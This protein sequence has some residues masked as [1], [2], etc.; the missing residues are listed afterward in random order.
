MPIKRKA[1]ACLRVAKAAGGRSHIATSLL[2]DPAMLL[3]AHLRIDDTI[4]TS[5]PQQQQQRSSS[6]NNGRIQAHTARQAKAAAAAMTTTKLNIKP[7]SIGKGLAAGGGAKVGFGSRNQNIL[8]MQM[9]IG[10]KDGVVRRE[11]QVDCTSVFSHD[12]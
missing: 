12:T 11:Y 9:S 8:P 2:L 4:T 5:W 7:D 6:S 3:H 10:L 1:C